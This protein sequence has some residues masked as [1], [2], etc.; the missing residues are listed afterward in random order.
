MGEELVEGEGDVEG[1]L[2]GGVVGA[3]GAVGAGMELTSGAGGAVG[4]S[5]KAGT[6]YPR[7]RKDRNVP[8]ASFLIFISLL[9]CVASLL[10]WCRE[11]FPPYTYSKEVNVLVTTDQTRYQG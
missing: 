4:V 1:A 10:C 11:G 9:L 5:A 3:G 6:V 8:A 7:R 2:E